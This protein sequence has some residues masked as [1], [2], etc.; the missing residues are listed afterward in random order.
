MKDNRSIQMVPEDTI[1]I[2]NVFGVVLKSDEKC[3]AK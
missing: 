1:M 3:T 2:V